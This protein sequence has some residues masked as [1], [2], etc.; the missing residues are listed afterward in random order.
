MKKFNKTKKDIPDIEKK[1][2][3][4]QSI[5][6]NDKNFQLEIVN[7]TNT[8]NK[9]NKNQLQNHQKDNDSTQI[10]H[11]NLINNNINKSE[12]NLQAI[13]VEICKKPIMVVEEIDPTKSNNENE[14]IMK[15]EKLINKSDQNIIKSSGMINLDTI[16]PE[17][18]SS[19]SF[20]TLHLK[21]NKIKSCNK[22]TQQYLNFEETETTE[23]SNKLSKTTKIPEVKNIKQQISDN[24]KK[25]EEIE[26]LNII[27]KL[28]KRWKYFRKSNKC[29]KRW[30][31][32]EIEALEKGVK[33]YGKLW[34]TI[35]KK[36]RN[37]F[38]KTR[39]PIDLKLKY[40]LEHKKSSYYKTNIKKWLLIT[41]QINNIYLDKMPI[42][43]EKFPYDAA[44]KFAKE[45]NYNV[46]YDTI[47]FTIAEQGFLQN[48]HSYVASWFTIDNKKKMVLKK[49]KS[50][51]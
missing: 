44:K 49:I 12:K 14:I 7:L 22:K 3:D 28:G 11:D 35:L 10:K 21:K 4:P 25:K 27:S 32:N 16:Q 31:I 9:K 34:K 20:E 29:S 26:T 1:V 30:T 23:L 36:N 46:N 19:S 37:E 42:I 6:N 47:I 5:H 33:K 17:I 15:Q 39:R 41:T 24:K 13:T 50:N 51:E 43:K 38:D 8:I 2:E 18:L 45:L 40:N 48:K